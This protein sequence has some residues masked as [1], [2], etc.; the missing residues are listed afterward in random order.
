MRK[1]AKYNCAS[2]VMQ[3]STNS[4]TRVI[5]SI[6]IMTSFTVNINERAR[7]EQTCAT[8]KIESNSKTRD[9]T[10]LLSVNLV[11]LSLKR[12]LTEDLQ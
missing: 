1:L 12:R 11:S 10:N 2:R 4:R 6:P 7:S 8:K 3:E 9:T 5:K